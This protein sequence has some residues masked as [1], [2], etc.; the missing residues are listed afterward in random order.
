MTPDDGTLV[1]TR[2]PSIDTSTALWI[3]KGVKPRS[4]KPPSRS[5]PHTHLL[6]PLIGPHT[7]SPTMAA[8][9]NPIPP[10]PRPSVPGKRDA[11]RPIPH[12]L[13]PHR[14]SGVKWSEG[15]KWG[16]MAVVTGA[17]LVVALGSSLLSGAERSV[18][19]TFPGY[20]REVYTLETYSGGTVA[21]LFE[22]DERG[23]G[24]VIFSTA[25][26]MGPALGPICGGF[27]GETAG[28]RWVVALLAILS[29]LM[30]LI[31]APWLPET[32]PIVLLRPRAAL[33]SRVTGQ[34]YVYKGDKGKDVG[35]VRLYETALSRPWALLFKEPIVFLL[36]VY[37]AII[38]GTLYLLFGAF[39]IVFKQER[40]WSPGIGGLSFLGGLIGWVLAV[41][42]SLVYENPR[43]AR[44][45][46]EAGGWLRPEERLPP[47][48]LG[49]IL[50]P[51]FYMYGERIRVKTKFGR[52]ANEIGQAMRRTATMTEK[53]RSYEEQI[54]RAQ[55][56]G[57]SGI[58][59]STVSTSLL[60][61][62]IH[63][64]GEILGQACMGIVDKV[65]S[66]VKTLTKGDRVVVSSHIACG[67]C[68]L[69]Q[70][71][72]SYMCEGVT[73]SIRPDQDRR[74]SVSSVSES[75]QAEYVRV[76][77]A[78]FNC[79]KVPDEVP[80]EKA[81]Y[82]SDVLPNSYH[83]VQDIGIKEGD[84]VGVWGLGP[85]GQ[86][87]LRW[88]ALAGAKRIY[89]IDKID[90]RLQLARKGAKPGV[91]WTINFEQLDEL[92]D[93]VEFIQAK[94]AEGLDCAID[95]TNNEPKAEKAL[96]L[97]TDFP[98][99]LNE[100]IRAVRKM[101]RIGVISSHPGVMNHFNSAVMEKGIRLF[102]SGVCPVHLYWEEI[103]QK[104]VS[105][106]FDPTFLINRRIRLEDFPDFY[107]ILAS[108]MPGVHLFFGVTKFSNAEPYPGTPALTTMQQL[109]EAG[110]RRR[111][112][113][114]ASLFT[115]GQTIVKRALSISN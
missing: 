10:S 92:D 81:L 86:C 103:L 113:L 41:V 35:I 96:R 101:G 94:S 25:P 89:A 8:L 47:A 39:P 51:V 44:K 48:I 58:Q 3:N 14:G 54:A 15:Y 11:R 46:K 115:E 75:N 72:L 42:Y 26:F 104:I 80:D 77:A 78:D 87:V 34:R 79:L 31:G 38:I 32:Y 111:S 16:V 21:D 40:G 2:P 59:G 107:P 63:L 33:L 17:T 71:K 27:L 106:E 73:G 45:L 18:Q 60:A 22:A 64:P 19:E 6:P 61:G 53:T 49:G 37:M 84:V 7:P 91:V 50:L 109:Q 76:P 100:C 4:H 85:L 98:D 105:N 65:G 102:G 56:G 82:L 97:E 29:A 23:L 36:A 83:C 30:T 55:P 52:E 12:R 57:L 70:K 108:Q 114:I 90:S 69:C 13:A 95:C 67:Q 9:H 88:A 93:V 5:S 66:E 1:L 68:Q 99:V 28:W 20:N 43:Y 112:S 24:M 110:G 74:G 62:D